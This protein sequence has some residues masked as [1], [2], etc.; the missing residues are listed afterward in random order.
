MNRM[1]PKPK[2]NNIDEKRDF[3]RPKMNPEPASSLRLNGQKFSNTLTFPVRTFRGSGSLLGGRPVVGRP[4]P[5][6]DSR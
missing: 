1:S 4:A 5:G 2:A 6:S 3:V